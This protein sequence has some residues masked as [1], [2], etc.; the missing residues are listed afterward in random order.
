MDLSDLV[1]FALRAAQD[2]S[3]WEQHVRFDRDR[4]QWARLAAPP[5]IDLWLLTWLPDQRTE[6]HD[7]GDAAAAV[8]V[9]SGRLTEVRAHPDGRLTTTVLVPGG[10]HGL[11]VGTVHDVLS[12]GP[13]PAVSVHAY[14]P[15]LRQMTFYACD[16]NGLR[17]L[18]TTPVE[19]DAQVPA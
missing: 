8:V 15:R 7:H 6:L 19:D 13:G 1:S 18:R 10:A 11:P 5:D 4:R 17:P 16:G 2:R 12:T 3:Q 9:L 14:T